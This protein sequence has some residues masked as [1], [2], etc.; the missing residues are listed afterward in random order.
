M[1]RTLWILGTLAL[2]AVLVVGVLQ[3]G[4][5][6]EPGDG[7]AP[8][9]DLD[10]ALQRLNGAPP[11]IAQLHGEANTVVASSRSDFERRLKALKG[12]PVVVN[13]W[14]SWCGPCKLE[15]PIFQR[16]STR[17]GTRVA[18]LGLNTQD[19]TDDAKAY[20]AKTPVPYPSLEDGDSRILQEAGG[21][22]GLP[23]TIFYDKDGE[24]AM[25]HQGG[26]E[27]ERDLVEAIRRYA[28]A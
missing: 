5:G 27:T 23:T 18:F 6:D 12:Y 2:V 1:R 19:N 14:A 13:A 16:V 21:V 15:F 17:L 22:G 25:V 24:R 28:G 4:S 3:A 26:Y 9:F 8:A 20:L 10:A 7:P 11:P